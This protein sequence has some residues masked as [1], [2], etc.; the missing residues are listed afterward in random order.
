VAIIQDK[1]T[2]VR[3]RGIPCGKGRR[4]AG[5]C[6]GILVG[7]DGSAGSEEALTWAA[8]EARAREAVLTVC[9]ACGTYPALAGEVG[10]SDLARQCGGRILDRALRSARNLMG[11]GVVQPLLADGPA[12]QVLCEH[13]AR[14]DMLVVGSRGEGGLTGLLLGSASL[15]VAAHAHGRV[16]VVRGHWRWAGEYIPGPIVVGVD[17]SEDSHAAVAF[18]LE[19]AILRKTSVLAVCA[20]ADTVGGLG[21][22]RRMA[23]EFEHAVARWV[24]EHHREVAIRS[25]VADGG[26]RAALLTAA[27]EAQMLV[28]GSRGRGGVRG[29]T[30]GSVSQAMLHHAPC[31][32]SVVHAQ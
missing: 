18:A 16:V 15:Q 4:L 25:L 11:S 6:Y 3:G 7:Y 32:V 22:A 29:M 19:E 8:R 23:E 30:L 10:I 2:L 24:K 13:S 26:A 1:G 17:G 20:L 27:H 28:V 14:A 5:E 21:G 31:P 9:Q 12:A